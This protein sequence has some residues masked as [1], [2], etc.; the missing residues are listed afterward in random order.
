MDKIVGVGDGSRGV[1]DVDG[2]LELDEG[3]H[4]DARINECFKDW[5]AQSIP[6]EHGAFNVWVIW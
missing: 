6:D 3:F 1:G 2:V 5:G 4:W